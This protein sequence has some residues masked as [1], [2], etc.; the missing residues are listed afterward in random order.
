MIILWIKWSHNHMIINS[1]ESSDYNQILLRYS[2][3]DHQMIITRRHMIMWWMKAD[4]LQMKI[5]SF[6]AVLYMIIRWSLYE[7][8]INIIWSLDNHMMIWKWN[9]QQMTN[10]IIIKLSSNTQE[11]V[12]LFVFCLMINNKSIFDQFWASNDHHIFIW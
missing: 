10:K 11:F 8:W 2:L 7:Q 3:D 12:C 6:S 9:D 1:W 4:T 5:R